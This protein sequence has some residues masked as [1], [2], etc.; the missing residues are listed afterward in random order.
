MS[1]E[2]DR[3]KEKEERRKERLERKLNKGQ[4]KFDDKQYHAQKAKVQEDLEDALNVGMC[5][6]VFTVYLCPLIHWG[7]YSS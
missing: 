5:L 2:A 1:K 7:N 6:T 4:H 3:E